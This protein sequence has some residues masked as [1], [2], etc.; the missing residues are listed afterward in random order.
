MTF[1]LPKVNIEAEFKRDLNSKV[2]KKLYPKGIGS[3]SFKRA[4]EEGFTGK[5]ITVAII[6]TGIDATHPDLKDK[7]KKSFNL[8]GETLINSHGTH[9]AGIIAANGWLVGGAPDVSLLDIKV[10][11]I[12]GGTVDNVI[13]GIE[14]A[15][16]N[17][18]NIINLSLGTAYLQI[19][20]VKELNNIINKAWEKGVICVAAAGN[21]GI[22]TGTLDPY[23]YPAS[24][25][26]VESIAACEVGE[27]LNS[28]SL[29]Y[30]SNENNKV[31]LSAC[32]QGVVSTV[33]GGKYAIYSGTSMSTPHVSAMAAVLAQYIT[34]KYPNIK[35]KDFSAFLVSLLH[36]NTLK[37]N[38][39]IKNNISIKGRTIITF[40]S[41]EI[42]VKEPN[43]KLSYGSG[44]LRYN[45]NKP[46]TTLEGVKYYYNGLF[47]GYEI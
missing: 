38:K 23:H 47:L 33:I 1:Y 25:D 22:S 16:N 7:V 24:L 6:D 9:V 29:A 34:N 32:G 19:S 4:W 12:N 44:F 21:E 17:G 13:R 45:N 31:D 35:G 15:I 14:L 36:D 8:T 18:A 43:P 41:K 20:Q 42:C 30:Y 2:I 3:S 5:G 28:I 39:C 10:L 46:P 27:N 37:L 40:I 11:G 26:K